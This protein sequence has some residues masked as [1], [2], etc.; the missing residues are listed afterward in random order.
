[1]VS[2]IAC[3]NT[4]IPCSKM[5]DETPLYDPEILK[6]HA[7]QLGDRYAMLLDDESLCVRPLYASDYNRGFLELLKELTDVVMVPQEQFQ[8]IHIVF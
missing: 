1:M 2:F 5:A 7:A 8:S 6:K 4:G 3:Q